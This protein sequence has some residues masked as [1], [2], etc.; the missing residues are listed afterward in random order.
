[1][2][3]SW[4]LASVAL[5]VVC[6]ALYEAARRSLAFTLAVF[7]LGPLALLPWWIHHA[8]HSAFGWAKI[9][10]VAG[11]LALFAGMRIG[12]LAET[13]LSRRV[14]YLFLVL[15][16]V[17]AVALGA[18]SG[19]AASLV[20]AGT[21]VLL[22]LGIAPAST[23]AITRDRMR[24]LLWPQTR[25]WIVGYTLWNWALVAMEKYAHIG[26]H[27]AI[28]VVALVV[29][30]RHPALWFQTRAYTL[31]LFLMLLFTWK[32]GFEPLRPSEPGP[33][34]LSLLAVGAGLFCAVAHLVRSKARTST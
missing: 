22:I 11:A 24:D 20:N 25:L 34:V 2:P 4:I 23:V 10:S 26:M 17:E 29:G 9:Y 7:V 19:D 6:L 18:A 30:L 1:M 3:S 5:G 15:N 12:K 16:I 21:G 32:P 28:L 8:P 27:S 33:A 13:P 14:I 31:G